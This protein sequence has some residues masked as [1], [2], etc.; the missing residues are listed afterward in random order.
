MTRQT[1][2]R[3]VV[4]DV[5]NQP[6]G[7][8]L[9]QWFIVLRF[10][11]FPLQSIRWWLNDG[12]GYN[13]LTGTW[14]INNTDFNNDFLLDLSNNTGYWYRVTKDSKGRLTV[15]SKMNVH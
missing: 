13:I 6:E 1:V 9:S 14:R 3:W 5:F 11:L 10:I 7:V 8:I 4:R 2:F 15:E 12:E